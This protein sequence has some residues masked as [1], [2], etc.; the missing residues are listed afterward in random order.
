VLPA[1]IRRFHEAKASG[2]P[3]VTLWGTG[4]ALR[5]FLHSDDLGAAILHVL[6]EYHEPGP[7]NVGYGED[8][9]IHDLA[10][11]IAGIVGYEGDIEWDDSK[12]DGTPRKILDSSRI[13]AL[14]W[15]PRIPLAD[16]IRTTYDAYRA[17]VS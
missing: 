9:T 17:K 8:I 2:A 4:V 14:G 12:P 16:G 13:R 15:E 1:L 11:L 10:T 6:D 5:E 7:I 3:S